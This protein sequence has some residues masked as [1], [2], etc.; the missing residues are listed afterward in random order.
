MTI[1]V[2]VLLVVVVI[3]RLGRLRR[4]GRLGRLGWRAEARSRFDEKPTVD[5]VLAPGAP[6]A[7]APAG[8]GSANFPGQ[9]AS[10]VA[11][12]GR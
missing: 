1:G 12:A 10:G 9:P 8:E 7:P 6:I 4:L 11:Q 2:A 3:W 5:R